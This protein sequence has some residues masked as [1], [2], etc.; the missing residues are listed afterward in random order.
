MCSTGPSHWTAVR[1]AAVSCT[2]CAGLK[3]KEAAAKVP[4]TKVVKTTKR[5]GQIALAAGPAKAA[6]TAK[7]ASTSTA[8]ASKATKA[9]KAKAAATTAVGLLAALK[10]QGETAGTSAGTDAATPSVAEN[11][12]AKPADQA[13]K[14]DRKKASDINVE[15]AIAK[16][17]AARTSGTLAKLSL[18]ELKAYLKSAGKPV[19]GKKAELVE[20]VQA[21]AES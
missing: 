7:G 3:N 2:Q 5:P 15:E 21:E 17:A 12:V 11:N 18:L 16:V 14:R 4:N 10:E 6:R 13:P 20:R 8:A 19:G 9:T 1:V